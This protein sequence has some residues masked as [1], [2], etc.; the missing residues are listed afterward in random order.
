MFYHI[1]L[2]KEKGLTAFGIDKAD[3]MVCGMR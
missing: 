3:L 2:I 1:Y